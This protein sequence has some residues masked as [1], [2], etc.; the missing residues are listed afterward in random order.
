MH[1]QPYSLIN[2]KLRKL[3][4]SSCLFQ[5][6]HAWFIYPESG[7]EARYERVLIFLDAKNALD[8]Q[9]RVQKTLLF[10]F[11]FQTVKVLCYCFSFNC[12]NP[13]SNH[14][15]R[16]GLSLVAEWTKYIPDGST[17]Q[18]KRVKWLLY[19]ITFFRAVWLGFSRHSRSGTSR[20]FWD[21]CGRVVQ[22][23]YPEGAYL[24]A[25]LKGQGYRMG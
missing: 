9:N 25:N 3:N 1:Q 8:V 2:L 11:V 16:P 22:Y 7:F 6:R 12:I 18:L 19:V 4:L 21:N 24:E 15:Q 14:A 10:K 5:R 13:T 20:G 23:I 17:T